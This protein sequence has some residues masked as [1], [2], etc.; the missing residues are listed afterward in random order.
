MQMTPPRKRRWLIPSLIG[1]AVVLVLCCGGAIAIGG[2][3][4]P[5]ATTGTEAGPSPRST[6]AAPLAE[7][8]PA[9]KPSPTAAA[10]KPKPAPSKDGP[11][12]YRLGQ[13][14]RGGDFQFVV[15]R[16]KCGS[17]SVG[18]SFLNKKAQ[19]TFCQ[20]DIT[21]KNVTKSAHLFHADGTVT[22]QDGTD[23]EYSA[24]GE[25]GI[26]GNKNGQGFLEEINP[27]NAIRASVYFDVPKGTKLTSI[28]F[29]A[30]LFTLA[31][32]AV[33]RL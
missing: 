5:P 23:R 26:Y 17:T 32:D 29:D 9:G 13:A 6:T 18:T 25:A 28:T 16:V 11:G 4:D 24:D 21:V 19:G 20:V 10:A 30:G 8:E 22:A 7:V 15:H 2:A 1:G 33:V 27:G 14:V 31:K 12:T 3:A